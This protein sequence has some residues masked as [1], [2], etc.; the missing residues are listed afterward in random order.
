MSRQPEKISDAELEVMKTVWAASAP[1][2]LSEIRREVCQRTG[3]ESSTVKTLVSRLTAKGALTQEKREVFYY[4]P[5]ISQADYGRRSVARLVDK[6]FA[7]SAKNMVAALV[8]SQ[9][10]TDDDLEELR[11]LLREDS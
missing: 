4:A 10:L 2:S 3:W 5:A 11:A 6:L 7:G 8:Q 9:S 1:L